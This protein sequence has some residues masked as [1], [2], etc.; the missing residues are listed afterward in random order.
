MA[1]ELVEEE[2]PNSTVI[3]ERQEDLRYAAFAYS[4]RKEVVDRDVE[5]L[6]SS[7]EDAVD[8]TLNVEDQ[9]YIAVEC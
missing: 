7:K 5:N 9:E 6:K 4:P 8:C 3:L 1:T 2:N